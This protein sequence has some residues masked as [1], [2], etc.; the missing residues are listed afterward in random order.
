[1][2]EVNVLDWNGKADSQVKLN[3]EVFGLKMEQGLLHRVTIVSLEKM[4]RSHA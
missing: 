2:P 3:E 1:M 4:E